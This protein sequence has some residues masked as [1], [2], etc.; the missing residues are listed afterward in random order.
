M[1]ILGNR[2]LQELADLF[3]RYPAQD[4]IQAADLLENPSTRTKVVQILRSMA[5][6]K[7]SNQDKT[8]SAFTQTNK[9][10]KS[11]DEVR[12]RLKKTPL[13]RVRGIA[14]KLGLK[15]SGKDSRQQLVRRLLATC[16]DPVQHRR[17]TDELSGDRSDNYEKWFNIIVGGGKQH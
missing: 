6:L 14:L 8:N 5:T 7:S 2:L 13:P 3:R 10:S 11:L 16:K 1:T 4:W 9:S 17:L 15:V 12:T